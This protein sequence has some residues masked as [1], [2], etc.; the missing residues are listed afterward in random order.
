MNGAVTGCSGYPILHFVV[1]IRRVSITNF[2]YSDIELEG[3][4]ATLAKGATGY[5]FSSF[6][7][8]DFYFFICQV[9]K[10]IDE[11]INLFVSGIDLA[12]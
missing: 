6:R 4:G 5:A 1:G 10:V 2:I 8:Y 12:L 11:V 9:I 7:F 3:I